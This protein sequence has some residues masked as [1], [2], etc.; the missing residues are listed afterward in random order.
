MTTTEEKEIE[1]VLSE[2][3]ESEQ[4]PVEGEQKAPEA[5]QKPEELNKPA[6]EV[7]KGEQ[8]TVKN[9]APLEQLTH[10][11]SLFVMLSD[12]T[13][14]TEIGTLLDA[15]ASMLETPWTPVLDEAVDYL[16]KEGRFEKIPQ[17][18]D[19]AKQLD[20]AKTARRLALCWLWQEI[21][22]NS[23]PEKEGQVA[24][25][26]TF[27]NLVWK[28]KDKPTVAQVKKELG[29][30]LKMSAPTLT[31]V[32]GTPAAA[33]APTTG[34]SQSVAGEELP[35]SD[36]ELKFE[37]LK[38]KFKAGE[39]TG[40][41]IRAEFGLKEAKGVTDKLDP[42]KAWGLE[43]EFLKVLSACAAG[44]KIVEDWQSTVLGSAKV[45]VKMF[46]FEPRHERKIEPLIAGRFK[47][48]QDRLVSGLEFK[49]FVYHQ[50][51]NIDS[52]RNLP[53]KVMSYYFSQ[54]EENSRKRSD[55]SMSWHERRGLPALNDS[56]DKSDFD[57][58]WKEHSKNYR[59]ASRNSEADMRVLIGSLRDIQAENPNLD[60]GAI[61]DRNFKKV[62]REP[63]AFAPAEY[64][65][66]KELPGQQKIDFA[67]KT[68][69]DGSTA[70]AASDCT[71]VKGEEAEKKI[72]EIDSNKVPAKTEEKK[73]E[74]AKAEKKPDLKAVPG[75]KKDAGDK[76]RPGRS[77]SKQK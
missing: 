46:D 68:K 60:V 8:A 17:P 35:I 75:G 20:V 62:D 42:N 73:E 37:N 44:K 25:E 2:S 23:K 27:C 5:E 30:V 58:E 77:K 19:K 53:E 45:I 31:P 38:K 65:K 16:S 74:P 26:I 9:R 21:K 11:D 14:D 51:K 47:Q 24:H 15:A 18:A 71:T 12:S 6:E 55:I 33:A 3:T 36:L 59:E 63:D 13:T 4:K 50:C 10:E 56:D 43:T 76:K 54:I 49:K 32:A 40:N 39:L 69:D 34:Q 7:N 72:K 52:N 22:G 29:F 41:Q 66:P 70:E 61:I 48:F 67:S 28:K 64:T 57:K 1:K